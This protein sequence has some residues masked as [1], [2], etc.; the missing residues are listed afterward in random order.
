MGNAD[1][2]RLEVVDGDQSERKAPGLEGEKDRRRER[3]GENE[4]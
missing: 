2:E 1:G 4:R 3:E